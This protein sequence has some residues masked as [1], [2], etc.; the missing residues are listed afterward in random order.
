MYWRGPLHFTVRSLWNIESQRRYRND[1]WG[2]MHPKKGTQVIFTLKSLLYIH[3]QNRCFKNI[4]PLPSNL[5]FCRARPSWKQDFCLNDTYIP[6][7][8]I[9]CT[10]W[11][12]QIVNMS[13]DNLLHADSLI[14]LVFAHV[15]S[16][17]E[18]AVWKN[19]HLFLELAFI[20][21]FHAQS[22]SVFPLS[23]KDMY[24]CICRRSNKISEQVSSIHF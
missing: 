6:D 10:C 21:W 16:P 4:C 17:L 9:S 5:A 3:S 15:M 11:I 7:V 23:L 19:K 24:V 12:L 18:F 14:M 1:V 22:V 8:K 13:C 20:V 2:E